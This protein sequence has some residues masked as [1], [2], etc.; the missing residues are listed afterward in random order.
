MRR[1]ALWIAS[2]IAAVVLLFSYRTSLGG[3]V[4]PAAGAE[5]PGIVPD[6]PG[7]SGAVDAPAPSASARRS[8]S[9]KTVRING[10]VAQ[11]RWGPVQIQVTI[12]SGRITDVR[13]LQR[14]SGN[15]RDDEINGYAVPQLRSEVL[16]AQSANI[17]TVSGATVTS[18]GYI[19][20][21][22]AALDAAHFG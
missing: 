18:G 5:A 2:T 3:S 17:D 13:A 1:I 14:P 4:P 6:S 21:L 16:S 22:Q 7:P 12:T 20:S 11:T 15:D 19:E 9:A 8:G 10:T